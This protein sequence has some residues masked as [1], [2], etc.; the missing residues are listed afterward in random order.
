[1]LF[2]SV[3]GVL[4]KDN[5]YAQNRTNDIINIKSKKYRSEDY[6]IDK[7]KKSHK[8]SKRW[9]KIYRKSHLNKKKRSTKRYVRQLRAWECPSYKTF[10][11]LK[12]K[13]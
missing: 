12:K 1:M 2:V 11:N 3:F 9:A 4:R 6:S 8:T 13:K 10:I 5:L 7:L